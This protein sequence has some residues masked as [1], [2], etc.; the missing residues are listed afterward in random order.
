MSSDQVLDILRRSAQGETTA[1]RAITKLQP[2]GGE[3]DKVLPPTY[4]DSAGKESVYAFEKRKIEGKEVDN[5]VLDSVQSQANRME[6]AL[7]EAHRSGKLTLPVFEIRIPNHE[8]VTSLTAPHR[9]HDAI[10]RDSLLEGK[11]FRESD[12]GKRL[13]ASRAWN[14]TAF[15]E[16]APTAMLFGT[17]DSQ[18]GSG[19]NSAKVARSLVS[20]IVALNVV[21]GVK[22]SSRIDPLGIRLVRDVISASEKPGEMWK[23]QLPAVEA[24]SADGKKSKKTDAAKG[25]KPSEINHG[26]VTPTIT[27]ENGPGGVTF[28]E[29]IQTAVLSFTQLRRLRFPIK[30]GATQP[31]RDHAGP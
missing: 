11:P 9:I 22:T 29:A 2:A 1:I 16:Y 30:D 23:F 18:S 27:V 31:E 3:G 28:K 14:A 4:K 26:N 12:A 17:W 7:L 15:Y 5:V 13:V 21:R 24:K 25:L 20:E 8:P 10:L 19:T 6:E